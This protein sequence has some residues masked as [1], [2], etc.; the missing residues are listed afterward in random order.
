[1]SRAGH[2]YTV[3]ENDIGLG[4]GYTV[5]GRGGYTVPEEG[6][7]IAFWRRVHAI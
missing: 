1:M 4:G 6:R 7:G 2:G 3:S 5:Q